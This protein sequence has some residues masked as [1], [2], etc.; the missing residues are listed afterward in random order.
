MLDIL[1]DITKGEGRIEDM[2]LLLDLAEQV[3][4]GSLCALGGTA[5]NPVIT[6]LRYFMD[7][8]EEHITQRR[9]RALSCQ[10]LISF[11]ID[12]EKCQGCL[13]CIRNCSVEAIVGDKRMVHVVDQGK[14]IK[15]GVCL[16][17]CPPKFDAVVKVSGEEFSA[18][19]EPIPVKPLK[20][21]SKD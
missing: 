9:C 10:S 2:D 12:P 6:T 3:K 5:P 7:E 21:T 18:P 4:V 8:Y 20:K 1:E 13:I 16:D 19:S 15:C 17:I 11:Y 14:C